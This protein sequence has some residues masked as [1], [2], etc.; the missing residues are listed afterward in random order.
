MNS[1]RAY[2]ANAT[3]PESGTVCQ[4]DNPPFYQTNAEG[5][6]EE[7]AEASLG[8]LRLAATFHEARKGRLHSSTA[9]STINL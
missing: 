3:L 1:I 5:L 6:S 2:F 4:L 7:E 8:S 9:T